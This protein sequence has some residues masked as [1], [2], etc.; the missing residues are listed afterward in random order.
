METASESIRV[1]AY[2]ISALRLFGVSPNIRLLFPFGALKESDTKSPYGR[3][4]RF[5]IALFQGLGKPMLPYI[6]DLDVAL[7]HVQAPTEVVFLCG[8]PYS[9]NRDNGVLSLRHAFHSISEHPALKGREILMAED[10][11]RRSDFAAHYDN[12]L[13]FER[14]IAQITELVLLFCESEGSFAELGSFSCYQEIYS[15]ML[16]IVRQIYWEQNS[17]I[18][19][20]P[21]DFLRK[22]CGIESVF[23]IPDDQIGIKNSDVNTIDI[24]LFKKTIQEPLQVRLKFTR[25]PTTFISERAGHRIKLIVGLIQEYGALKFDEI[26]SSL[27]YFNVEAS[28]DEI[29]CYLLCGRSVGWID[30]K[31][32]GFYNYWIPCETK[33]VL[34]FPVTE[35]ASLIDRTRRR[36]SI[37]DHWREK[38]QSRYKLIVPSVEEAEL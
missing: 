23:V 12:L 9:N 21:L 34:N 7:L 8:G 31:A 26:K 1:I 24:D 5:S 19:L 16:V 37:I 10:V 35:G 6:E 11:T 20:G 22:E 4:A 36:L 32:V 33:P 29:R 30:E 38:D 27:V 3:S 17:F 14:D 28:D 25:E 15:Q 13:S 18:R 2:A